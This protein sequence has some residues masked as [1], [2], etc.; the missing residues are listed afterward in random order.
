MPASFPV[1][2]V[3]NDEPKTW[4][5]TCRTC[6]WKSEPSTTKTAVD[7]VRRLHGREVECTRAQ[8]PA[9][10][11]S[12]TP[13]PAPAA[14]P[15]VDSQIDMLARLLEGAAQLEVRKERLLATAVALKDFDRNGLIVIVAT[16]ARLV[17]KR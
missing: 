1:I 16:L 9:P 11:D 12:P 7:Y 14:E 3:V 5:A 15:D 17:F 13:T 2:D 4:Q 6:G 10:L 8:Q